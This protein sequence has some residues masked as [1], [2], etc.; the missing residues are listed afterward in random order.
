MTTA[1]KPDF[2]KMSADTAAFGKDQMDA[3]TKAAAVWARGSEEIFK[4]CVEL[5]QQT[6]EKNAEAIKSLMG[7]KTLNELTETQTKLAQ[8]NIEGMIANATKLSELSVK[9][10]TDSFEPLN[11]QYSKTA[12]KATSAAA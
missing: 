1:K 11:A 5:T 2:E 6:A 8:S 12:K 3:Y 7:C 4:A 9:V 10:A